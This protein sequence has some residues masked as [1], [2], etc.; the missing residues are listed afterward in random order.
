MDWHCNLQHVLSI[1]NMEKYECGM[2][3]YRNIIL[4]SIIITVIINIIIIILA[5]LMPT[6]EHRSPRSRILHG[7]APGVP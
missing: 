5:F 7:V 3:L 1:N 4:S 2:F 6:A